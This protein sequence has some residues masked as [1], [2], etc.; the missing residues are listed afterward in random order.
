MES[1]TI[2][3]AVPADIPDLDRLLYQVHKVHSDARP[4]LFIPGA[5][6]Y[7]DG[8]L[9][10]ILAD[11]RTPVFA[12]ER[13][14]ALVGYA[15]C[16]WQQHDD[17]RSMTHIRT[18]YIDDLCIDESERGTGVGRALYEHVLAYARMNDFYNV[19]LNVWEGNG[20]ALK[21]YQSLG[22]KVQKYGMEIIL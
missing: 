3:R 9:E 2:R 4:D 22:L 21:F 6:K 10:A 13:D 16:V 14:G 15:F 11:E 19:T 20:S 8:E 17:S 18:L 1:L 12:A 7:T 5:K